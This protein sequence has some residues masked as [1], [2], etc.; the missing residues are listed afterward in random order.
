M[1]KSVLV[2]EDE[3]NDLLIGEGDGE[4]VWLTQGQMCQL[5]RT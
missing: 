1:D 2:C 4:T 5:C 3:K